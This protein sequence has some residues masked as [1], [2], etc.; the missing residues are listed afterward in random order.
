MGQ[1]W[2]N[3]VF[4]LS[5][6]FPHLLPSL[7]MCS[8]RGGW[9]VGLDYEDSLLR[10][11]SFHLGL[12]VGNLGPNS[13]TE[14]KFGFFW[15]TS[16]YRASLSSCLWRENWLA[17]LFW[18]KDSLTLR[19]MSFAVVVQS[20]S[21]VWLFATP[22]TAAHQAPWPS[23][24]PRVCSDSCPLNQWCSLTMSPS[25]S[26]FSCLQSFPIKGSFPASWLFASGGLSTGASTSASV[27][28]MD[29]QGNFF[30]K[31]IDLCLRTCSEWFPLHILKIC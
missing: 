21:H 4:F 14:I 7:W 6:P 23:L 10:H 12:E 26:P 11:P 27:L 2:E 5:L 28:P 16:I 20:L 19:S 15:P 22:W 29:I 18:C 1:C 3:K 8:H 25:A 9:Q 13:M 17:S 31:D 24:S 30:L